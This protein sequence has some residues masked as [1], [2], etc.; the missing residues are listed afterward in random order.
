MLNKQTAAHYIWA[1]ARLLERRVFD[2]AFF[3]GSAHD[4]VQALRAYQNDDGGF[5]NALEPDLRAPD[6]QPLFAEFGLRTLY[7]SR[8]QDAAL[9]SDVCRYIA[10]HADLKQGIA[11]ITESSRHYPRAEHWNHPQSEQPSFSRLTGLVGL[12]KWQGIQNAWLDNAVDV[13]LRHIASEKYEDSHTILTAFCLLESLPQTEAIKKL[14]GKLSD[15]LMA[16]Q[17]FRLDAATEGYGLTPLDFAPVANSYCRPLFSDAVIEE[18]LKALASEQDED[19][20]WPIQW[21]P[22]SELARLE[23]RAYRTVKSLITLQSYRWE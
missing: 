22:P 10:Q 3:G 14:Y 4:V 16:A 9:A 21:Q 17:W 19:G 15:E 5:G 11:T 18:H 6:S 20:G 23:W 8:I 1:N 13:C 12:L 7:E 2:H